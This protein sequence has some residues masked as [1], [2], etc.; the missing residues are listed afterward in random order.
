LTNN[1]CAHRRLDY[2]QDQAGNNGVRLWYFQECV[3]NVRIV[4]WIIKL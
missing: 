3:F 1:G 4:E 2:Q